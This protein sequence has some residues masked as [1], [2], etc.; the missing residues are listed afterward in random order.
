MI[1]LMGDVV[2]SERDIVLRTEAMVRSVYS[3]ED[4]LMLLRKALWHL[5]GARTLNTEEAA[6]LA[7]YRVAVQAA[8][9][10]G[11]Q[12]RADNTKLSLARAVESGERLPADVSA[13]VQALLQVRAD[14]RAVR[15][16]PAGG[17]REP[18]GR[19]R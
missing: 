19:A 2:W 1:D 12:A 8:G 13:D 4:E 18:K 17:G 10:E 11:A 7:E 16:D 14:A 5:L 9:A 3:L 6:A 15:Q